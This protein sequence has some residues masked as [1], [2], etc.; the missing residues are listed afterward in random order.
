MTCQGENFPPLFVLPASI[1]ALSKTSSPARAFLEKT[2]GR[3]DP[4][5][6]GLV[7]QRGTSQV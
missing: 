5:H 3:E 2:H 1:I 7:W 6:S 4:D